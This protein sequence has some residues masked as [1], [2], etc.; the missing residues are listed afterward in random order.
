M[1]SVISINNDDDRMEQ[2]TAWPTELYRNDPFYI[3]DRSCTQVNSQARFFMVMRKG[4]ICGRIAALISKDIV[5]HQKK[6]GLIGFYECIDADNVA[7]LLFVSAE[8]YLKSKGCTYCIG[9]LNGSTWYKYRLTIPDSNPPFFLDNYHKPWYV[10]QF[11]DNSFVSISMY[12]S[13]QITSLYVTGKRIKRLEK[14]FS[15]QGIIIR[16]IDL[17]N[18]E[19]EIKKIHTIC[20]ASFKNNFLYTPISQNELAALYTGAQK[21]IDPRY[22]LICEDTAGKPLAFVFCVPDLFEK[23]IKTLV[24]KTIAVTPES[25]GKGL[26]TFLV[27]KIHLMAF[28]NDFNRIIH[29]LMQCNNISNKI[30]GDKSNAFRQYKL[31]GKSL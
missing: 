14:I 25:R 27:E 2:F 23:S 30:V 24:I 26:G 3:E 19:N 6:T 16:S 7:K 18:F 15:N 12:N 28:R 31:Y 1:Y 17:S 4:R 13:S 11:S 10:K 9:P 8:T 22:V 21:F 29:A 5:Y 20:T